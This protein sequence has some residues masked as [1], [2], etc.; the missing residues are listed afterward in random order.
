MINL[1]DVVKTCKTYDITKFTDCKTS[2]GVEDIKNAS[3]EDIRD[4]IR[5]MLCYDRELIHY[6]L[7]KHFHRRFDMSGYNTEGRV[8]CSVLNMEIVNTFQ[9]LGIYDYTR[10]LTI[11]Y[12][13]GGGDLFYQFYYGRDEQIVEDVTTMGTVSVIQRIFELTILSG[14]QK[15]RREWILTR[16]IPSNK[17]KK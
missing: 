11:D 4:Y 9:H 1:E 13:K 2:W 5:Q 15:R 14:R 7:H 6:G 8:S 16:D 3:V 12:V 10:Y 17:E